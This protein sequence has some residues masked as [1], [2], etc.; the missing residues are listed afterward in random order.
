MDHPPVKCL[1]AINVE[2][3]TKS[4]TVFSLVSVHRYV[5]GVRSKCCKETVHGSMAEYEELSLPGTAQG[6]RVKC[7]P[8]DLRTGIRVIC[9]PGL[10]FSRWLVDV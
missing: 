9:G 6:A 2:F 4:A 10:Q 1:F 3:C 8:A 5:Y 7:R